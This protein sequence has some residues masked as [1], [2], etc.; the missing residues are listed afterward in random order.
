MP[1]DLR[2]FAADLQE[3]TQPL[4]DKIRC[5]TYPRRP[6]MTKTRIYSSIQVVR[7]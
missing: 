2:Q 7:Q 3:S 4:L 1:K 6:I 5:T